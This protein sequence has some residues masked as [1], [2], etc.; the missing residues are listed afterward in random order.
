MATSL[1]S[2]Q[3]FYFYLTLAKDD[4]VVQIPLDDMSEASLKR[5]LASGI[6]RFASGFTKTVALVLPPRDPASG[7]LGRGIIGAQ[8]NRLERFLGADLNVQSE[9][10]SDGQVSGEADILLLVAPRDLDEKQLFAVDQ[11][12][13]RGGTVIAATSP[14][15]AS[16]S[17]RSLSLQRAQSGLSEWLAFQGLTIEDT[18]VLDPQ[19]TSFPIPVTRK[20]GGFQ[21]QE[22]RMLDYP[23]FSDVRD[24]G[25]NQDNAITSDLPQATVAW[26]SPIVVANAEQEGRTITEI[27][28]SSE[29][30]WLSASTDVMP[31]FDDNSVDNF[32][33]QGEPASQLLGVISAG[34]FESYFAG[35]TSPLLTGE[36]APLDEN[37]LPDNDSGAN[38]QESLD[39]KT[40]TAFSVIERSPQ[41]ARIILLSSNDFLSDQVL[42]LAGSVGRGEYLNTLQLLANSIDWSLED[43]GL[44]SI[45][46]RGNFNRTLRPLEYRSQLFWEYLNY[47]LAA[48][49]LGLVA[50]V[51]RQ[52][53]K[54]RQRDTIDLL[55]N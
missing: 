26:A 15:S 39:T 48:V 54:T 22:I 28:R 50:L 36:T 37:T 52:R 14:Y 41:S 40:D 45:R 21:F 24:E 30:S 23:F 2:E 42:Q 29:Q 46:A 16:F 5:N 8:F 19:N 32:E 13:M 51:Q 18:L 55:A 7:Q 10:L 38:A 25:L 33:P 11:F 3:S 44:L 4:Q 47:L 1:F 20:V 35:K 43:A 6:K 34:R 53:K 12:L 9:D 17:S 49:A 31:R 27:L